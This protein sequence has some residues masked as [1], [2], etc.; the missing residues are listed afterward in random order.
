[1]TKKTLQKE[2]DDN[3]SFCGEKVSIEYCHLWQNRKKYINSALICGFYGAKNVG[4]E[5]MLEGVIKNISPSQP[6]VVMLANNYYVNPQDYAPYDII[7]FP[8]EK[9]DYLI[10][11]E[12]F[13]KACLC[14]GAMI[15]DYEYEFRAEYSSMSYIL[16]TIIKTFLMI[17]KEAS[18]IGVS[19]NH[20]IKEPVFIQDLQYLIDNCTI[21]TLRDTNSLA[22][23]QQA[24]VN[25]KKVRIIDDIALACELGLQPRIDNTKYTIGFAP[26][27]SDDTFGDTLKFIKKTIDIA[28]KITNK[29]VTL[30]L[31]PF[32]TYFEHDLNYCF[33]MSEGIKNVPITIEKTPDNATE[34]CRIFSQ[35]D[36][37]ITSRYHAALISS[38]LGIRTLVIDYSNK[39][40]HYP[41]KIKYIKQKYNPRLQMIEVNQITNSAC[42]E[43]IERALV[44][45][46]KPLSKRKRRK[47]QNNTKKIIKK[48]KVLTK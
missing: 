45:K 26:I 11:A 40:R 3:Y 32:Y 21:F 6:L 44:E 23:I 13:T 22:T 42:R 33:R 39:H 4:D 27:F 48:M 18:I 38:V 31:I 12:V 29:P 46:T 7:H 19:A 14:G 41:N 37:I 17:G 2:A 5:L 34:L 10:L 20:I 30:E 16:L 35:C 9:G 1:M 43:T 47:I 15:D 8:I 28:K 24:G 36:I 25:T